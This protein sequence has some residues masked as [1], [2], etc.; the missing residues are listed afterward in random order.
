MTAAAVFDIKAND[1]TAKTFATVNKRLKQLGT[2]V[3]KYTSIAGAAIT[4][5]SVV[6]ARNA[7]ETIAYARAI[8]VST[9]ELSAFG[10]AAESVSI[11]QEK[12]ND[13][14]KDVSEKIGDAYINKGGEAVEIL[15]RLNLNAKDMAAL[16]P[17]KQLL[18]IAEGMEQV[19]TQSEK[20]LILES[21]ASDASLL[22]PLLD[23]GAKK[24][25]LLTAEARATGIVLTDIDAENIEIANKAWDKT[26]S[27]IDG[28]GFKIAA[29]LS[30][31]IEDLSDQFSDAA[32][33]SDG[34]SDSIE[35]TFELLGDLAT[36]VNENKEEL[37]AVA[38][39]VGAVKLGPLIA[40]TGAAAHQFVRARVESYQLQLALAKM[41]G[42]SARAAKG[43][44]GVSIASRGLSGAMSL[45]G[46]PVGIIAG[47]ITALSLWALTSDDASDSTKELSD[48]V[49]TLLGNYEKLKLRKLTD[50]LEEVTAAAYE[51]KEAIERIKESAAITTAPL[52]GY[53][54][55]EIKELTVGLMA[56]GTQMGNLRDK[57]KELKEAEAKPDVEVG[58]IGGVGEAEFDQGVK[59]ESLLASYENEYVLL[60]EKHTN[61][62]LLLDQAYI[63]EE[64]S[65]EKHEQ[66]MAAIGSKYAKAKEKIDDFETKK[67]VKAVQGMLGN[68]SLLM[69]SGNKKMFEIGKAAAVTNTVISTYEAAQ[70]AYKSLAGIPIVGPA[71]GAAAALAAIAVG[72]Q[73][74][75]AIQGTSFGS[76]AVSAGGGG[77]TGAGSIGG[78]PV[79]NSL[80]PPPV[81]VGEQKE[82]RNETIV[83][84][85]ADLDQIFTGQQMRDMAE[86]LA[87]VNFV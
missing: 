79:N 61:E 55:A 62:Q 70:S 87:D 83:I 57:I 40:S 5:L 82:S 53:E 29:E 26:L 8:G 33:S 66:T 18:K 69:E 54:I 1:Q 85:G 73:R 30:P 6:S 44:M 39:V 28:V 48:R 64:I 35:T 84:Q 52:A 50:A 67:K 13:I 60:E 16:S 27:I 21:L 49:D 17:D 32:T 46:G 75:S 14:L 59:L 25:K 72:Q 15:E 36:V 20:I 78:A 76:G 2:D 10:Y 68:L 12:L 9:E 58:G 31:Y 34:F 47:G 19:G 74:V 63:A 38:I 45:L 81:D 41:D 24:L 11:S 42:V 4:G 7:K 3:L 77:S 56:M 51:Q 37:A 65:K 23:D 43:M 22:I 71:L 86:R 80:P